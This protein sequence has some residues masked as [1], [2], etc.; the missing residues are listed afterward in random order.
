[1]SKN[2]TQLKITQSQVSAIN[3]PHDC[4]YHAE[5]RVETSNGF[6]Y[7]SAIGDSFNDLILDI[8]HEMEN[9]KFREPELE[10]AIYKPNEENSDITWKVRDALKNL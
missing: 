4:N 5:I 2:N 3:V 1:M 10:C 9:W 6:K 8:Q 7:V